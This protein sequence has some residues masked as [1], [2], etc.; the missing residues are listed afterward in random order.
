MPDEGALDL[1]ALDVNAHVPSWH[2]YPTA[3]HTLGELTNPRY[4]C[5]THKCIHDFVRE[6]PI[7]I[8]LRMGLGNF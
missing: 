8:Q 4:C 1:G 2:T 5:Y 7:K 6:H 3:L